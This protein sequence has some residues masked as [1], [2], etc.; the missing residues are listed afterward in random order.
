MGSS[1]TNISPSDSSTFVANPRQ[2]LYDPSTLRPSSIFRPQSPVLSSLPEPAFSQPP[3]IYVSTDSSEGLATG[4]YLGP[5]A[6][7]A[8]GAPVWPSVGQPSG[9]SSMPSPALTEV[10]SFATP[11]GLLDPSLALRLG[12]Q[13]MQSQ[14]ALSF[15]DDMDYSRPIGGM[16]NNRQHSRTT[17]HTMSTESRRRPSLESRDTQGTH[18][19]GTETVHPFAEAT[20]PPTSGRAST[21]ASSVHS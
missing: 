17:L 5:H 19:T 3:G 14:G 7:T 18:T 20:S 15:R 1:P 10:S 2:S 9:Q 13:G 6:V 12:A 11:E 16:V 4:A 8:H 21:E